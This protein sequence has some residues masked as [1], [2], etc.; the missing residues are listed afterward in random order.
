MAGTALSQQRDTVAST[1]YPCPLSL[2]PP[3]PPT[4]HYHFE[5][6]NGSESST[7]TIGNTAPSISCTAS[8]GNSATCGSNSLALDLYGHTVASSAALPS[9]R[10][11]MHHAHGGVMVNCTPRHQISYDAHT[12]FSGGSA[13]I[14]TSTVSNTTLGISLI[15]TSSNNSFSNNLSN[16]LCSG[17]GSSGVSVTVGSFSTPTYAQ[18]GYN[19]YSSFTTQ[20]TSTNYNHNT[21]TDNINVVNNQNDSTTNST[22]NTNNHENNITNSNLNILSSRT[23]PMPQN[24]NT[25][26]EQLQQQEHQQEQ[27]SHLHQQ[28][29]QQFFASCFYSPWV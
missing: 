11:H 13:P 7:N 3:L 2:R 15:P 17:L 19:S 10:T 18:L 28:Q 12:Y 6:I 9:P 29:Q 23:K 4:H 26:N 14:D 20:A 8:T 5:N 16:G 21:N 25:S 27:E 24:A 22:N 1:L